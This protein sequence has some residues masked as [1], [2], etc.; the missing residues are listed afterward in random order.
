MILVI[1]EVDEDHQDQ[2]GD[3]VLD[4]SLMVSSSEPIMRSKII[5]PTSGSLLLAAA[6]DDTNIRDGHDAELP[7][8]LATS[9]DQITGIYLRV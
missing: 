4:P 5:P 8:N 9:S 7:D 3:E 1:E 6:V 2:R